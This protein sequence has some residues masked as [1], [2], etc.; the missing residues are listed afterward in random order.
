MFIAMNRFLIKRGKEFKREETGALNLLLL[1]QLPSKEDPNRVP[2]KIT[3]AQAS[4]ALD[5]TVACGRM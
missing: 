5:N 3:R 2:R 4:S 1:R